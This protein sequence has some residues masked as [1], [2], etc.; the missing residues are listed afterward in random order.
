MPMF[1]NTSMGYKVDVPW[2]HFSLCTHFSQDK[3]TISVKSLAD[4]NRALSQL[5]HN[6]RK[7]KTKKLSF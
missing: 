7:P 6:L 2:T 3:H 4:P 5:L 1:A